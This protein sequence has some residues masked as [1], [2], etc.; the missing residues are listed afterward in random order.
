M[1]YE[2]YLQLLNRAAA[3]QRRKPASLALSHNL[4][5]MPSQNVAAV[6][7]VGLADV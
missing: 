4:G 1:I 6:A 7:I 2:N 3:R 5:G